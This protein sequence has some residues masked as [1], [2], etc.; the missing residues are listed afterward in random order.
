[1]SY[2]NTNKHTT[3][4][5]TALTDLSTPGKSFSW[6]CLV[7]AKIHCIFLVW[8]LV[9]YGQIMDLQRAGLAVLIRICFIQFQAKFGPSNTFDAT[10]IL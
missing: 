7:R 9:K 3:E 2:N 5:I 8:Q 10:L 6:L 1:M 4:P